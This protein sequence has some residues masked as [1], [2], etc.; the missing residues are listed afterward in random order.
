MIRQSQNY[1]SHKKRKFLLFGI[2]WSVIV[3]AIFGIGLLK[4]DQRANTF[5]VVAAVLVLP[6]AQN[7]TRFFAFSKYRDPKRNH[8]ELLEQL[9]GNYALYHGAIVPDAKYS[10]YFEH[11][12]VTDSS[13][14]FVAAHKQ[15]N[16]KYKTQ[17]IQ[18]LGAKGIG[19]SQV[20]F[21]YAD[22]EKGLKAACAKI[23][24]NMRGQESPQLEKNMH[25]IEGM[26][27]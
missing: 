12:I 16:D 2:M 10:L 19:Y 13:L 4:Y 25:I 11:V 20:H 14:Y 3:A 1:I 5:T 6:L 17:L 22:T 24:K 8:A 27:M 26:L 23:Q 7:F 9:T 18:R 15:E 21:V